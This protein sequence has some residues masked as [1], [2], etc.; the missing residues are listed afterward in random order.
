[1]VFRMNYEEILW[2]R[3]VNDR[4]FR[5]GTIVSASEELGISKRSTD[6]MI[7]RLIDER[8]IFPAHRGVYF[9]ID[10]QNP[11]SRSEIARILSPDI[12]ISLDSSFDS[13]RK[14]SYNTMCLASTDCRVGS[15]GSPLGSIFISAMPYHLLRDLKGSIES[16]MIFK[17]E[18]TCSGIKICS[19]ELAIVQ[20][21]SLNHLNRR[22]VSHG[23]MISELDLGLVDMT[24]VSYIADAAG[25]EQRHIDSF[26]NSVLTQEPIEQV[27][28]SSPSR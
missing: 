13:I 6:Y 21:S 20:I 26:V 1:M 9:I 22:G 12:V 5:S 10:K 8:K 25:V 23:K 15:F 2:E 14:R 4:V 7:R 3:M 28:N 24:K 17:G 27:E 16:P 11:V 18:E 19:H